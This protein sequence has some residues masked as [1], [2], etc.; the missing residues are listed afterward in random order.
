MSEAYARPPTAQEAVLTELRRLLVTGELAPGT[1]VRQEAVAARLGVSRVPVREAL[2]VLEG[3][4]H[5]VYLPHRGYV[6]AELSVTDLT[7]VYRLRELLEAEAVRVAVPRVDDATLTAIE[8]AAREVD[9]AGRRGDLAAMTAYNR[10]FHFLLF[11]AA[12][13]PRLSRTLRQLWDATD[14]YRSVYFAGPG[15][16]T[17][18]RHDHAELV[19]ALRARDVR[20]AVAVQ[21]AHRDHS[22]V[23]VTRALEGRTAT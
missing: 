8:A 11:D 13:M 20:R 18:V 4:G 10:D 15:N 19:D 5:V 9:A 23:A 22:V 6:V 21:K 14:V 7:E 2:K 1:P 3:E 17:R 12:G 16:R